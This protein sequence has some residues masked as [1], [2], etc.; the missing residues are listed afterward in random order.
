MKNIRSIMLE[1]YLDASL[2]EKLTEHIYKQRTDGSIRIALSCELE[3]GED[4]QYPLSDILDKYYV[5]CTDYIEEKQ[6]GG[7]RTY[8][9]ELEGSLGNEEDYKNILEV[10]KLIGKRVYNKEVDGFIELFIE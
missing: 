10:S 9:F 7:V 3:E 6:D 1:K 4:G 5:N 8:S 2:F